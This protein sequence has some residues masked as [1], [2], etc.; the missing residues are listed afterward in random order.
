MCGLVEV[1]EWVQAA[2]GG[3][4]P[5][6][7]DIWRSQ[8]RG[9]RQASCHPGLE[10]V[11]LPVHLWQGGQLNGKFFGVFFVFLLGEASLG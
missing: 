7:W 6:A 3:P 8:Q 11:P 5:E 10:V 1:T 2:K 4:Q 9:Q